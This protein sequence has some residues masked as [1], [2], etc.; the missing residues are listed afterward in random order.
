MAQL[1]SLNNIDTAA[2]TAISG[3]RISGILY[4]GNDTAAGPAG[5]QTVSLT[6]TGFQTGLVVYVN[7]A[8][9]SVTSVVSASLV[10]FVTPV[11]AAG[12]YTLLVVNTDGGTATFV[13]GIQYSGVPT[14]STGAGSLGTA[15]E[16]TSF[17]TTLSASSDSTVTYSVYSGSLPIGVNL[18]TSTGVI[19]GTLPEVAGNTTYN[20]TIRATDGENQDTDRNFSITVN[21]IIPATSTIEYLVVAGGGAGGSHFGGGG[22]AGGYRTATGFAVTAGTPITVTVGAGGT[23]I[24]GG[25]YRGN[26]G[27]DS[28]FG[29][30]ISLGGGGGGARD[31]NK[32]GG[33]GGSGGGGGGTQSTGGAGTAGQGREGEG[34]GEGFAQSH[35]GGGGGAGGPGTYGYPYTGESRGGI[36]LQSSITGTATY[37]AGGGGGG[38]QSP[39]VGGTG[40]GANGG[41][42][43]AGG[44]GTVNTGGGGGGGGVSNN[45]GG[46]GGSG[47]VVIRYADTYG[48]ASATTGSPTITVAGGYRVYKFTSS[49]SIT[50]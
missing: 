48:E 8:V 15:N 1:I 23:N 39:G 36:G 35:G 3:P 40:G 43:T 45:A 42:S 30:I 29:T 24:A 46:S 4:P 38:G 9:V 21:S 2:I 10:T 32:S 11:L 7:G 20:F 27:G 26:P 14:W 25:S 50:F 37:Y 31:A 34:S 33:S 49:G 22:G 17:S 12:S 28:V 41:Q 16:S 13:P 6:G 47:I 19:S 5:G 44:A 18:N